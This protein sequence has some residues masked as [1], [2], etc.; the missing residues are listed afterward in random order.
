MALKPLTLEQLIAAPLRAIVMGQE[1]AAQATAEFVSEVGFEAKAGGS[2]T[3]RM[4]EFDYVHPMPDP[5]NPGAVI[6]TPTRVRV[7]LLTM[8]PVPNMRLAEATVN[9]SA[10]I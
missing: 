7:P 10:D 1:A 8:V 4:V 5:E 3:V 2:P 6:P 9:F